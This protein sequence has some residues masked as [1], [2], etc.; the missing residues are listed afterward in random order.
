[1]GKLREKLSL[2]RKGK[3]SASA[4]EANVRYEIVQSSA[5]RSSDLGSVCRP[6]AIA[7]ILILP[8]E[9][10]EIIF[11]LLDLA[12]TIRLRQ[13]CRTLYLYQGPAL[14]ELFRELGGKYDP[15]TDFA[16][17]CFAERSYIKKV[18]LAGLLLCG[19]CKIYHPNRS[20]TTRDIAKQPEERLCIGQHGR[21]YFTPEHSLSF[22]ELTAL[23]QIPP[24]MR[25]FLTDTKRKT[26]YGHRSTNAVDRHTPHLVAPLYQHHSYEYGHVFSYFWALDVQ[27]ILNHIESKVPLEK[28]HG[29][30]VIDLCPHITSNNTQMISA[31]H[32]CLSKGIYAHRVSEISCSSPGFLR[33]PRF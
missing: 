2:R 6:A 10:S 31:V 21:L 15:S 19:G 9:I 26:T 16:R 23:K 25:Y 5:E 7:A 4:R 12:S 8:L 24:Y 3:S 17:R 13:T 18:D 11:D 22:L 30:E 14:A 20:F 32:D 1:M 29:G 27:S 33:F 28:E